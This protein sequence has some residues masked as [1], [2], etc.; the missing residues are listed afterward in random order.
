VSSAG[1][2]RVECPHCGT[3]VRVRTLVDLS[4]R[5]F[6]SILKEKRMDELE[7]EWLWG[8]PTDNRSLLSSCMKG[9]WVHLKV[10][11][12]HRLAYL[13]GKKND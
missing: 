5:E 3:P 13:R 2:P 4:Q 1:K 6:K 11:G 9:G 8:K 7:P 10:N 12:Q